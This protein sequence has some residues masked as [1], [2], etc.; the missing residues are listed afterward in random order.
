[1]WARSSG[2]CGEDDTSQQHATR[3][4]QASK[5]ANKEA[6]KQKQTGKQARKQATD[7][8]KQGSEQ[9][10][11]QARIRSMQADMKQML[12]SNW[13]TVSRL[14]HS[15]IIDTRTTTKHN[16]PVALKSNVYS[17]TLRANHKQRSSSTRA[18][19]GDHHLNDLCCDRQTPKLESSTQQET[20]LCH[21]TL[22]DLCAR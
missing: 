9:T 11:K 22:S 5:H 15:N 7:A 16:N 18:T 12:K 6:R 21:S 20:H 3:W 19:K 8:G 1:M 4:P 10:R 14:W 17:D 2:T 13:Y